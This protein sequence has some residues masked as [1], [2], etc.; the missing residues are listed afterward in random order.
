VVEGET[1]FLTCHTIKKQDNLL[2]LL[3]DKL[4][5]E[6][7]YTDNKFNDDDDDDNNNNNKLIHSVHLLISLYISDNHP[8]HS[9]SR[10]CN[11]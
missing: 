4:D 8:S 7:Q 11:H 10:L 3:P 6:L 5:K 1:R 2:T 9:E